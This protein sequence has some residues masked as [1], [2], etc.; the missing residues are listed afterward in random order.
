MRHFVLAFLFLLAFIFP[1]NIFAEYIEFYHTQLNLNSDGTLMVE[2]IID[3]NFYANERHGIYRTIPFTVK[4]INGNKFK[5]TFTDI[6]ALAN[7]RETP[8]TQ[9]VEG[10]QIKLKIGN[11]D[12]YVKGLVRYTLRYR[13]HGAMRYFQDHDE[14]YWNA[15]G[16]GWTV[17]IKT[18]QVTVTIPPL[19]TPFDIKPTCYAHEFGS[20]KP[21]STAML[22]A[23]GA[24]FTHTN[25]GPGEGLTIIISLPKDHIAVLEPQRYQ[26]I[27]D[28]FASWEGVIAVMGSAAFL[29]LLFWLSITLPPVKAV[30]AWFDPPK[31]PT[32]RFLTPAEAGNLIDGV[33]SVR[34]ITA[35]IVGLAQKGYIRIREREEKKLLSSKNIY[36]VTKLKE[37]DNTL[38]PAERECMH[39]LF[40][41]SDTYVFNGNYDPDIAHMVQHTNALLFSSLQGEGLFRFNPKYA[42][43]SATGAL[44]LITVMGYFTRSYTL[45]FLGILLTLVFIVFFFVTGQF[46]RSLTMAGL[47]ALGHAISLKNFLKSQSR[48]LNFQGDKQML[49]EKLLP[50]AV[51]FGVE[52][53]WAKRFKDIDLKNPSWYHGSSPTFSTIHFTQSMKGLSNMVSTT[54]MSSGSGGS[55]S[56]GGGGGG[57]G[58]G[59]W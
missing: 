3:Y 51:A 23:T 19:A 7:G 54:G 55:G 32:G 12:V 45:I 24:A 47:Q 58:G 57:G 1:A 20:T 2:E 8:V 11:P 16:T 18:A 31:T 30:T 35:L 37:P 41:Q 39:T 5:L 46:K 25:L 6:Q 52:K 59:S 10:E 29:V 48:Q 34:E 33:A 56:S 44:S 49:F 15:I 4:N 50:Y 13:V 40:S 26:P 14:L 43:F 28:F 38:I 9:S 27:A 22:T 36:E 53:H 17:P 21:C 42:I